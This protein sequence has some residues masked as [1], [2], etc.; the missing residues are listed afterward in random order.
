MLRLEKFKNNI[1]LIDTNKIYTYG[2]LL[3]FTKKINK[4]LLKKK[5]LVFILSEN[6]IGS[7]VGYLTFILNKHVPLVLDKNIKKIAIKK[8]LSL[9]NPDY[10]WTPAKK[11]KLFSKNFKTKFC[12]LG[13]FLLKNNH[14]DFTKIN[15][16]LSLLSSTSG[17]TS[18]PKFVRQSYINIQSNKEAIIKYLKMDSKSETITTLPMSYTYGQSILNTHLATG[19]KIILTNYTVLQK[20]FWNLFNK[21]NLSFIYGVPYTFEILNK[22][23]F[24]ERNH[25][26]L[27]VI[28]V[29]G[30]KISNYLQKKISRYCLKFK[31]KFFIMYG[32]AEATTR[33]SYLPTK[34]SL[35]KIASIGKP[36]CDGRL[37]LVDEDGK[38]INKINKIGNLIYEGKNVCMGYS[39]SK[40]DLKKKDEWQGK[41]ITGDLAKKDNKGYFYLRG[42]K[43]RYAK[44]Y[45]QSINLDDIENY[46]SDKFNKITF[47]VVS[48]DV[49]IFIFH[50]CNDKNINKKI[51]KSLKKILTLSLMVFKIKFFRY[52]PRLE[53]GKKDYTFFLNK[54]KKQFF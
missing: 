23:N 22:L 31:K 18:S 37:Y 47:S 25:K 51:L 46:L 32:Q 52:I 10:I 43:K 48:N 14:S 40:C 26:S 13:Y 36:I 39:N 42:R 41:L 27:N 53:S 16:K 11:K 33:I 1:A 5:N 29:A 20:E 8:L 4:N 3:E 24:F 49:S 2:N 21:N 6:S 54:I 50:N 19:G 45:G 9:Y 12:I 28:A 38:K 34:L 7:V 30:G 44:I 17:T 35:K 15:P